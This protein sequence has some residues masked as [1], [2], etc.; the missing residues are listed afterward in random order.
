MAC[1]P[2]DLRDHPVRQRCLS[3]AALRDHPDTVHP[4][5]RK[6]CTPAAHRIGVHPA[7]P[8]DLL[9]RD[10]V[11]RQG[12]PLACITRRCGSTVDDAI[13]L[14]A[15]RSSSVTGNAGAVTIGMNQDYHIN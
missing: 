6:P 10:P 3:S 7:L 15:T 2:D 14:S 11:S 13:F 12:S 8:G 4:S 5:Q 9:I 1:Y